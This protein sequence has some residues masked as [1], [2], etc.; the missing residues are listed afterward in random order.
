[1]FFIRIVEIRPH[2]K[3][4]FMHPHVCCHD[5]MLFCLKIGSN[6]KNGESENQVGTE[7]VCKTESEQQ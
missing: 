6:R 5:Q 1:M 3:N 4:N 2:F 7:V